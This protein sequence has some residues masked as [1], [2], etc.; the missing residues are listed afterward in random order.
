MIF[1]FVRFRNRENRHKWLVTFF[2]GKIFTKLNAKSYTK[3][4]I[5]LQLSVQEKESFHSMGDK[6]DVVKFCQ[7]FSLIN[8]IRVHICISIFNERIKAKHYRLSM[9]ILLRCLFYSVF[10]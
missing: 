5:F 4:G 2:A 1:V 9:Q 7:P 6:V 8:F 3:Q 10:N